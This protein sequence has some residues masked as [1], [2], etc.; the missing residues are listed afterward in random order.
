MIIVN[1]NSREYFDGIYFWAAELKTYCNSLK[2]VISKNLFSFTSN[3]HMKSA[4][5]SETLIAI[6]FDNIVLLLSFLLEH[7][8]LKAFLF[9]H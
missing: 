4:A 8:C 9:C 5:S 3:I 7:F 2:S 6:T 1:V